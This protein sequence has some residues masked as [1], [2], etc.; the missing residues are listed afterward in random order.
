MPLGRSVD[1]RIAAPAEGPDDGEHER[2]EDELDHEVTVLA[3]ERR[4]GRV[5]CR[6]SQG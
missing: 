5:E 3:V 4:Y 2:G 1:P 6:R